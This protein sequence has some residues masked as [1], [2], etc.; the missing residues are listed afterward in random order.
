VKRSFGRAVLPVLAAARPHSAVRELVPDVPS[1]SA[2]PLASSWVRTSVVGSALML[3][4]ACTSGRSVQ[5]ERRAATTASTSPGAEARRVESTPAADLRIWFAAADARAWSTPLRE[6]LVAADPTARAAATLAVARLHEPAAQDALGAALTDPDPRVRQAASLG[7]SA[8]EDEASPAVRARLLGAAAT[9]SDP[10]TRAVLLADL[11]RVAGPDAEPALAAALQEDLPTSQEAACRAVGA[12]GLRG[13]SVTPALLEAV[14][15][16]VAPAPTPAVRLACAWS[17]SRQP[18]PPSPRAETLQALTRA[19]EAAAADADP[20]IRLMAARVGG[21]HPVLP[22]AALVTLTQD[23]DWRVVAQAFRALGRRSDPA[24]DGPYATALRAL[25]D[26][27]LPQ[28]PAAPLAG[29]D[30]DASGPRPESAARIDHGFRVALEESTAIAKGGGIAPLAEET[31][32]RLDASG[33]HVSRGVGLAHCLAARLVDIARGWPQR[34]FRCGLGRV[35]DSER[36][37]HAVEVLRRV[38]GDPA[39]RAGYLLRLYERGDVR[40]RE[41]ALAAT[42][43]I[44]EALAM[45]LVVRGLGEADVGVVTTALEA[46]VA[47]PARFL[48]FRREVSNAGAAPAAP[49]GGSS[50]AE[51]ERSADSPLDPTLRTALVAAHANLAQTNELEGLQRWLDAVAALGDTT[52]LPE[53]RV[54]ASDVNVTLRRAGRAAAQAL[55]MRLTL[56]ASGSAAG[57]PSRDG[58]ADPDA[59]SAS[60]EFPDDASRPPPNALAA[61]ALPRPDARLR[62]FLTLDAGEVEIELLPA[63]AP[64]TVAHFVALA[65]RGFYD[66]LRFHRVVPGF[67]VQ[68]GD[69]RGDGYGGPGF[70][71]RC[72]DN[73]VR[74]ERGTV[75]MALAGRDTGGSQFFIAQ[76]EQPHLDGRYTAFGRVVRGQEFVDGVL[77]DEVL[78]RVRIE[79]APP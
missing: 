30:V 61:T 16:R 5:G 46:V 76:S 49:D 58:G 39:G 26:A 54:H 17:I 9:E 36:D 66:G 64:A 31:L 69:P 27:R 63:E 33:A 1:D 53:V 22:V 11:G 44:D 40:V 35:G 13:R 62:A 45:R 67:V 10:A 34:V 14:A 2:R 56:R 19:F 47:R 72:E 71:Q 29:D 43:A 38:S 12:M 51:R 50:S 48:A 75:G 55:A 41:A 21:A 79:R 77:A 8:F 68:G 42:V 6:A 37:A 4:V 15:A 20:E 57:E 73:R 78:R 70:T 74:Y 3:L 52:F 25:L 24:H 65:E 59:V 32:R 18:S 23:A 28:R 60:S 7:L